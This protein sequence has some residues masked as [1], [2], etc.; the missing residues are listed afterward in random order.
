[1]LYLWPL[2][3]EKAKV[4]LEEETEIDFN[5]CKPHNEKCVYYCKEEGLGL[6]NKCKQETHHASPHHVHLVNELSKWV[7][8]ELY[9][10]ID[11]TEG[12]RQLLK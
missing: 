2:E 4:D 1:M 7:I 10:K 12:V 8:D 3:T 9:A 5:F 11:Q 6:C